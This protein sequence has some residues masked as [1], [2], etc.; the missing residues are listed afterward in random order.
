[1]IFSWKYK[2]EESMEVQCY[3]NDVPEK[4][5]KYDRIW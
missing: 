4:Q 5:N 1:M 2:V 3:K